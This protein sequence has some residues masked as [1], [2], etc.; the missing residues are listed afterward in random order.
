MN[1][2][3]APEMDKNDILGQL[4][5]LYVPGTTYDKNRQVWI[6]PE[7]AEKKLKEK[8]AKEPRKGA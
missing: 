8:Q 6:V 7:E 2:I 1:I 4:L 3:E 5:E